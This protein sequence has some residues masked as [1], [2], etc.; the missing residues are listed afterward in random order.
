[1]GSVAVQI[2]QA[3]DTA[4]MWHI[5]NPT[6]LT[7]EIGF[8]SDT[9]YFKMGNGTTP[10]NDLEY[11]NVFAVSNGGI[12]TVSKDSISNASVGSLSLGLNTIVGTNAVALGINANASA[13]CG[14]AIGNSAKADGANSI[15]IGTNSNSLYACIAIGVESIASAQSVAVGVGARATGYEG[16]AIGSKS[17]SGGYSVAIG[18]NNTSTQMSGVAIGYDAIASSHGVVIGRDSI[19]GSYSTSVGYNTKTLKDRS[20]AIGSYL[21]VSANDSMALGYYIN[22]AVP[23][24]VVIGKYNEVDI[25]NKYAY[26]FASG[27]S[28]KNRKNLHTIDHNGVAYFDGKVTINSNSNTFN[29]NDLITKQYH[30]NTIKDFATQ[31]FVSNSISNATMNFITADVMNNTITNVTSN[32]V[33]QDF[34]NN[35]ISNKGYITEQQVKDLI[36]N[37]STNVPT[38]IVLDSGSVLNRNSDVIIYDSGLVGRV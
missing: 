34:V 5:K 1:M 6:L 11:S 15:S 24:Q 38:D 13:Y 32:F 2:Q 3:H 8:E 18:S 22:V 20:I 17:I 10:W 37:M 16:I 30:D 7:G 33:T 14:V 29:D 28:D 19:A 25:E 27:N 23:N 9:G 31:N 35:A 26:I 12:H 21:N 4:L 36:A